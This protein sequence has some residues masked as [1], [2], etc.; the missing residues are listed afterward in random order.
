MTDKRIAS[1]ALS[2][3]VIALI[4][5]PLTAQPFERAGWITI[6]I[7]PSFLVEPYDEHA[8]TLEVNILP[9]TFEFGISDVWAI[10]FRP[11]VNLR[12][13]PNEPVSISH[14]GVSVTTT[15]YVD[16]PWLGDSGM[17]GIVGPV[18]TYA[19]NL[20]D[21]THSLTLAGEIGVSSPISSGWILDAQVQPGATFVWNSEGELQPV[22]PHIG[23]FVIPGY[24]FPTR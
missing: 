6:G 7:S 22:I 14:V 11:I 15:R 17:A 13:K 12:F 23:V 18:I 3:V 16:V 4:A 1:A 20:Q 21:E 24:R 9:F 2:M 5:F 8:N 10:E 19:Y